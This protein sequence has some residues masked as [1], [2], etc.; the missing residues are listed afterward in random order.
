MDNIL[1]SSRNNQSRGPAYVNVYFYRVYRKCL[2]RFQEWI[3]HTKTRKKMYI[4]MC[5]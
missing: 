4:N 2:D 3:P 1:F 5:P